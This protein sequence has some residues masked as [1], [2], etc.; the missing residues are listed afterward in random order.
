MLLRIKQ[1]AASER[2][3]VEVTFQFS[4]NRRLG[5]LQTVLVSAVSGG[6]GAFEKKIH[7]SIASDP[8]Y[9]S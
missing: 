1:L 2:D 6:V 5:F 9:C 7:L 3:D 4:V 8:T